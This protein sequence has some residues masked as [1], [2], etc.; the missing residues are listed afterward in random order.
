MKKGAVDNKLLQSMK[1][2]AKLGGEVEVLLGIRYLR[3]MPKPVHQ[4]PCGLTVFQSVLKLFKNREMA[5]IGGPI[6][7]FDSI[8]KHFDRRDVIKHIVALC[9]SLKRVTLQCNQYFVIIL[10][11]ITVLIIM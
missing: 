3:I 7:A 10:L 4:L 1:I 5:V 6:Q 8:T 11:I 9:S 2:P